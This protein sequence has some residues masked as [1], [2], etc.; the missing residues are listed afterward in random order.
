[1]AIH[2]NLSTA[3]GITTFVEHLS[4]QYRIWCQPQNK[5][6]RIELGSRHDRG[7][8]LLVLVIGSADESAFFP[9]ER[10]LARR[11]M[12]LEAAIVASEQRLTV[13]LI[14]RVSD[15]NAAAGEQIG[16]PGID[17]F[18]SDAIRP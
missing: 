14:L 8:K 11:N 17:H 10:I 7:R 9:Y 18:P 6:L 16:G 3:D 13:P 1:M 4:R 15:C 2:H 5:I 12:K